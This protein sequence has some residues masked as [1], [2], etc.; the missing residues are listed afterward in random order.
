MINAHIV[1][2]TLQVPPKSH[3][4]LW[5]LEK[6]QLAIDPV[7]EKLVGELMVYQL[8][9]RYPENFPAHPG[10]IES[11]RILSEVKTFIIWLMNKL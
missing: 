7:Q 6:T 5:L 11:L 10:K 9:G 2:S 8:E 4:L 1:K 3:N